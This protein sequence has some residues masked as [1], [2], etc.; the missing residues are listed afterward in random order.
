MIRIKKTIKFYTLNSAIN[1]FR[2]GLNEN[3]KKCKNACQI[4]HC[5][6]VTVK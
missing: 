5:V 4:P 1:S 3:L 2:K 6:G